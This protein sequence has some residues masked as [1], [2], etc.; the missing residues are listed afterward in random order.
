MKASDTVI[1]W[2]RMRMILHDKKSKHQDSMFRI[3]DI[4]RDQ[5]LLSFKA[6]QDEEARGGTNSLAY[7][8]GVLDGVTKGRKEVVE[9]IEEN[10]MRFFTFE[11]LY[12]LPNWESQLKEWDIENK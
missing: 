5:A 6:G 8:N 1:S 10:R 3:E 7:L 9:W 2:E 11:D 4:C 12:K